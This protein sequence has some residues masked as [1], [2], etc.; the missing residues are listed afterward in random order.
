MYIKEFSRCCTHCA[1]GIVTDGEYNLYCF[2]NPRFLEVVNGI[3]VTEIST[4]Y[5]TPFKLATEEKFFVR[6]LGKLRSKKGRIIHDAFDL[7][8]KIIEVKGNDAVV[9]IGGLKIRA[10]SGVNFDVCDSFKIGDYV[11]FRATR[12]DAEICPDG[13]FP[14]KD[15]KNI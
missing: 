5:N 3:K 9:L 11:E 1:S 6:P 14:Y 8:G 10:D 2:I 13:L 7:V 4:L 12:L 15:T